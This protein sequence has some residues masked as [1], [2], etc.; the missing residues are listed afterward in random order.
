MAFINWGSESEQQKK[1]R[2][3]LEEQALLEQAINANQGRNG[4]ALGVGGGSLLYKNVNNQSTLVLFNEIG[5]TNYR[6]YLANY[7]TGVINGP[8]DTGVSRED[9]NIGFNDTSLFPLQYSG[10]AM[11]FYRG[12][13]NEHTMLFLNSEGMVVESI[14]AISTDVTMEV[15]QGKYVVATDYDEG[16]LWVFDGTTLLTDNEIFTGSVGFSFGTDGN[17]A[18]T[19]NRLGLKLTME[20]D[21][22]RFYLCN[23]N[24]I[25]K[26]YET[27]P[28]NE[29]TKYVQFHTMYESENFV[30][31]TYNRSNNRLVKM[32][33]IGPDGNLITLRNIVSN[34]YTDSSFNVYGSGKLFLHTW[35][36]ADTGADHEIFMWQDSRGILDSVTLSA[37]T[38]TGWTY[39]YRQRYYGSDYNYLS[40]ENAA[41]WFYGPNSDTNGLTYFDD[42]VA[43]AIFDGQ[44]P[45]TYEYASGSTKGIYFSD[46]AISRNYMLYATDKNDDA[47]LQAMVMKPNSQVTFSNLDAPTT[48]LDDLDLTE[49]GDRVIVV[50]E[51]DNEEINTILHSFDALG[52]K[53]NSTLSFETNSHN[54]RTSYGV[55]TVDGDTNQQFFLTPSGNWAAYPS[56]GNDWYEALFHTNSERTS[57]PYEINYAGTFRIPY[58]HTQLGIDPNDGISGLSP[59]DFISDGVVASGTDYFGPG[60]SYFTNLYPGLFVLAAKSIDIETFEIIGNLGADGSG[61]VESEIIEVSGYSPGYSKTYSACIKKVFN[62]NDPSVNQI[63]IVDVAAES[64]SQ[65]VSAGNT[66]DN[67]HRVTG[68]AAATEVHYLLFAKTEDGSGYVTYQE[69]LSVITEYLDLVDGQNIANALTAL[70]ASY[71]NITGVFPA[72]DSG[73]P[74]RIYYFSDQGFNNISDGGGD[75]YD[76]G[77]LIRTSLVSGIPFRVFNASGQVNSFTIPSYSDAWFGRNRFFVTRYDDNEDIVI[78]SYDLGGNVKATV[79]TGHPDWDHGDYIEDRGEIL[80]TDKYLDLELDEVVLNLKFHAISPT[81]INSVSAITPDDE[82]QFVFRIVSN[83]WGEWND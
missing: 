17:Y 14:V 35:R 25:T 10:Y 13:I 50:V 24:Q 9:Y 70:N 4:Q 52:N 63:I 43:I 20:D 54:T 37:E 42:A 49:N 32:E 64:L 78:Q 40:V 18:T 76:T 82:P 46:E 26:V 62:S 30:V 6:Y 60:S 31:L 74:D 69:A 44:V 68:L 77:N 1:Y 5:Q 39:D 71:E 41:L 28:E 59:E 57:A 22:V 66:D 38:Y 27:T 8:F 67:L 23:S 7:S 53:S 45:Y 2:K 3:F 34:V 79:N 19:K 48:D 81:G 58:T 29:L 21:S 16:L 56:L 80:T 36:S 12:D 51:Y 65:S 55:F 75:M 73:D 15:Y 47:T 11:R 72:H 61:D 83:D 33:I